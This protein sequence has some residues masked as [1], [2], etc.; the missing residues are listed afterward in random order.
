MHLIPEQ[1]GWAGLEPETPKPPSDLKQKSGQELAKSSWLAAR[2]WPKRDGW[3]PQ[4]AS[5]SDF[6][7]KTFPMAR[8]QCQTFLP[9]FLFGPR[10]LAL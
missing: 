1:K 3:R 8:F 9:L 7:P 2:N 4:S 10:E 5:H 6:W